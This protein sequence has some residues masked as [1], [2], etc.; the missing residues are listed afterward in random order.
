MRISA[1]RRRVCGVFSGVVLSLSL[2]GCT[3]YYRVT[4]PSSGKIYYT[5]DVN[6]RDTGAV[7][8]KDAGTGDQVTLQ[9]SQVTKVSKEEFDS[10]RAG[11]H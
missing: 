9:N 10:N 2:M 6:N 5:H 8:F 7:S 1:N 11:K 3:S 4:D